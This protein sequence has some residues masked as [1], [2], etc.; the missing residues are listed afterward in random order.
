MKAPTLQ[1]GT[2]PV[3][4]LT[5]GGGS[6]S[7]HGDPIGHLHSAQHACAPL[8]VGLHCVPHSP[9]IKE[10]DVEHLQAA[11][12]P[13]ARHSGQQEAGIGLNVQWHVTD[14]TLGPLSSTKR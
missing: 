8:K 1:A 11:M 10:R 6:P 13:A 2:L 3:P 7:I 9:E 12:Q 5:V 14:H 4:L